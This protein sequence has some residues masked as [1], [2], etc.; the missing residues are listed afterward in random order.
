MTCYLLQSVLFAILLE[1]WSLDSASAR[2]PP[3]SR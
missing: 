1:P 2:G 3:A